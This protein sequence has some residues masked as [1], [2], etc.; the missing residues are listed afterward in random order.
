MLKEIALED[1]IALY[2]SASPIEFFTG[3]RCRAIANISGKQ[4]S[5]RLFARPGELPLAL[6]DCGIQRVARLSGVPRENVSKAEY[7]KKY[8]WCDI[9]ALE[10]GQQTEQH[11]CSQAAPYPM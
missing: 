2:H 1:D 4:K 5:P 10:A 7:S 9:F 11:D 3:N 6:I 8:G